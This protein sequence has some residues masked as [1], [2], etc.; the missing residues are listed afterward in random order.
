VGNLKVVI[1]VSRNNAR[2][3]ND[4]NQAINTPLYFLTTGQLPWPSSLENKPWQFAYF[5][6]NQIKNELQRIQAA[7]ICR[8]SA[9]S[10]FLRSSF[11]QQVRIMDATTLIQSVIGLWCGLNN[12]SARH[13]PKCLT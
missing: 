7:T 1:S 9:N 3:G 2:R 5:L 6:E 12:P 11:I 8:F 10:S 13:L 4:S